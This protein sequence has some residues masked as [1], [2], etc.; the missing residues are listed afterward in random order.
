M[1]FL[2]L[3][4]HFK[5]LFFRLDQPTHM[6]SSNVL[7]TAHMMR[8]VQPQVSIGTGASDGRCID[9]MTL[10]INH[11]LFHLEGGTILPYCVLQF[12]PFIST[13]VNSLC[14]SIVFAN[15]LH[16]N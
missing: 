13:G 8:M 14:I 6:H 1:L 5:S 11:W 9:A 4:K 12:L 3:K 10:P 15:I 7:M 16:V 2:M